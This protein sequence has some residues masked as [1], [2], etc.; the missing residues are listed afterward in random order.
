VGLLIIVMGASSS[1]ACATCPI[2]VRGKARPSL[3]GHH[4]SD[5]I[6][7]VGR[8]LIGIEGYRSLVQMRIVVVAAT[9]GHGERK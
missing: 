7:A 3:L 2:V 8:L 6:A 1:H 4:G 5:G 9:T